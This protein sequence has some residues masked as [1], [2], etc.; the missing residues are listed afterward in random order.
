M[1]QWH[2]NTR[3]RPQVYVNCNSLVDGLSYDFSV[4]HRAARDGKWLILKLGYRIAHLEDEG[5]FPAG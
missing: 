5:V 3:T 4:H 1:F 2:K